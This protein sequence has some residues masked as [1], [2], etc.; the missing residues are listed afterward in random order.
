MF[1]TSTC[2][3]CG[4]HAFKVVEQSIADA[5]YK[6]TFIQC[7]VCNVPV[8]VTE[9]YDSGFLL[10]KQ[11]EEISKLQ[12]QISGLERN[13]RQMFEMLQKLLRQ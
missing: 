9:Y 2:A 12:A 11:E 3:K 4:G 10:K 1:P 13:L 7:A 5:A 8:G 6:L